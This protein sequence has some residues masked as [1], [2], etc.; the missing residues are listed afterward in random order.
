MPEFERSEEMR[1]V[2]QRLINGKPRHAHLRGMAIHYYLTSTTTAS[3]TK[4]LSIWVR[5]RTNN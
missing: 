3:G 1:S 2:A 4:R 5:Q